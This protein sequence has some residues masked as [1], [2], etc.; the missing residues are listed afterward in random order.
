MATSTTHP[1][2]SMDE[3]QQ[4]FDTQQAEAPPTTITSQPVHTEQQA[5][6][7]AIDMDEAK[8]AGGDK[9]MDH[10]TVISDTMETSK[11]TC[12][13]PALPRF[14]SH[15]CNVSC[16]KPVLQL[17]RDFCCLLQNFHFRSLVSELKL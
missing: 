8:E 17:I 16:C 12:P 11:Y 3:S 4:P 10:L 7:S 5:T 9:N 2:S 15:F 6:S 1:S 13:T 14:F